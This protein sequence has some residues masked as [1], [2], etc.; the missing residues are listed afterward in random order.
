M[1]NLPTPQEFA[2]RLRRHD[3]YYAQSDD[4]R[5]YQR[6]ENESRELSYIAH[7]GTLEHKRE[8]NYACNDYK[9]TGSGWL[10]YPEA[11]L[12]LT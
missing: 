9:T 10:P 6:G 2:Q 7:H 4:P 5:V 3:W 12:P 11:G 8:Y 1:N